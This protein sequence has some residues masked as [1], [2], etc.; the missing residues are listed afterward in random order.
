LAREFLVAILAV[1]AFA[2]G[3]F[4]VGALAGLASRVFG[5]RGD[6]LL[7]VV[8]V[9]AAFFGATAFFGTTFF[10]A[11]ALPPLAA[12]I[13][14]EAAFRAVFFAGLVLPGRTVLIAEGAAFGR[15]TLTRPLMECPDLRA[16]IAPFTAGRL[17]GLL[18]GVEA[19][20]ATLGTVE[21]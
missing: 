8:R 2:V 7:T 20:G 6:A 12:G 9:A 1:P 13:R 16:L 11:A 3:A 10:A 19:M 21:S 14:T 5:R 4:A 18:R 15:E 17:F